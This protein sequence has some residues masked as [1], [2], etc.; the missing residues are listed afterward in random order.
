MAKKRRRKY[1]AVTVYMPWIPGLSK[2]GMTDIVE[3]DIKSNYSDPSGI[4]FGIGVTRWR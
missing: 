3:S 2:Q 1:I 4:E